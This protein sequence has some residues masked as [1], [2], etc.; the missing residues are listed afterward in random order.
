MNRITRD[1][2]FLQMAQ[3][4][5]RRSTCYRLNVGAILVSRD[6][7]LLSMG[8]NGAS[9][10]LQHCGGEPCEHFSRQEKKCQVVHAEVNALLRYRENS[11]KQGYLKVYITHSPCLDCASHLVQAGVEEVYYETEYRDKTPLDF[12]VAQQ[13]SVYRLSPSGFKVKIQK[14]DL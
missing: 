2:M 11:K 14:S 8:Y 9:A 1:Q 5:A 12:L 7:G 13:V 3:V 10:S 4:V 6:N